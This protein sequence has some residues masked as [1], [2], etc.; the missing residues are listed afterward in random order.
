[1]FMFN[2]E[3]I[4][5]RRKYMNKRERILYPYIPINNSERVI[6]G[7]RVRFQHVSV[8]R[9]SV[10]SVIMDNKKEKVTLEEHPYKGKYDFNVKFPIEDG[11][12]ETVQIIGYPTGNCQLSF[13]GNVRNLLGIKKDCIKE[14]IKKL[15]FNT[16]NQFIV[17]IKINDETKIEEFFKDETSIVMKNPYVSTNGSNMILYIFKWNPTVLDE[18]TF[19]FN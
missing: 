12:V 6:S 2:N 3:R 5:K 18:A 15:K 16:M 14:L 7:E 8:D 1:M 10:S 11:Y 9:D 13:I 19:E 17:D 4:N